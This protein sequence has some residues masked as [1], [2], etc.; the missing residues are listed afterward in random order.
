MTWP[1]PR[2]VAEIRA[3]VPGVSLATDIIVGFSGETDAQFQRTLDLLEEIR[4]DVVHVAMYSVRPG[5]ARRRHHAR[6]RAG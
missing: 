3:R 5:H 6:R 1:L 2:V 4:F